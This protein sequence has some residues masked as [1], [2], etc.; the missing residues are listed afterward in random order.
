MYYGVRNDQESFYYEE[1]LTKFF[2]KS[3]QEAGST[4]T[5]A[6]SR[7]I[8]NHD[9]KSG[10]IKTNGYV[11]K[12]VENIPQEQGSNILG[13]SPNRL[14]LMICGNK[15]ALG[16]PVIEAL[17]LTEDQLNFLKDQ[18]RLLSELWNE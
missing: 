17:K 5:L 4:L 7:S 11:T 14:F 15:K 3:N 6:C 9:K 13:S 1:F 2:E 12:A 16:K 10:I 8:K 18:N